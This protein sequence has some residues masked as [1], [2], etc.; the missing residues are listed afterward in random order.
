M[1]T[2]FC[3]EDCVKHGL[4]LLELNV[5]QL[6]SCEVNSVSM[7]ATIL[8]VP[9]SKIDSIVL[10]LDNLGKIP[11]GYFPTKPEMVN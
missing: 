9:V 1:L 11:T 3:H 4:D 5:L 6:I 10:K 2:P 8:E 7:I